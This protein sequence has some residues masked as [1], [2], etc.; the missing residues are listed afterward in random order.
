MKKT[1]LVL[2]TLLAGLGPVHAQH[3]NAGAYDSGGGGSLDKLYFVNGSTYNSSAYARTTVYQSSGIQA[4]LYTFS[5]SFT[6]LPAFG[7]LT[8]E[9]LT[10]N[11]AAV[12]GS[13]LQLQIVSVSGVSGGTFSYWAVGATAPTFTLANGAAAAGTE[14]WNLSDPSIDWSGDSV[15]PSPAAGT[16]ANAEPYGHIHGQVFSVDLPGT[17]ILGFKIVDTSSYTNLADSDIFYYKV[18]AVPEPSTWMLLLLGLGLAGFVLRR[19]HRSVHG[20]LW[21]QKGTALAALLCLAGIS[22]AEAHTHIVAGIVDTNGNSEGDPG[23]KLYFINGSLYDNAGANAY[24]WNLTY[25]TTGQT[26]AGFY[27][28]NVPPPLDS[29]LS[30]AVQ[31]ATD[32]NAGPGPNHPSLGSFI[33]LRIVS[34]SGPTGGAFSW[35]EEGFDTAPTASFTVGLTNGTYQFDLSEGANAVDSD[36]Y[37]HIHGRTFGA[38]LPGLYTLGIQLV[39]I[40]TFGPGG[41]PIQTPSDLYYF[42][43]YAVPEPSATLLALAGLGA[44][45]LCYRRKRAAQPGALQPSAAPPQLK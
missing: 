6:A 34:V 22:A 35:W 29:G 21:K 30:F 4:G 24:T 17:Y 42:N 31:P 7:H 33:Q 5:T 18:T 10:A 12:P 36:P 16:A 20:F 32:V 25:R 38:D 43:F 37:G 15:T 28:S 23:E 8:P 2:A 41:G 26:Y 11:P 3:I 19:K 44:I 27:I 45:L 9:L 39:D 1:F 14:R 40:S 13:F